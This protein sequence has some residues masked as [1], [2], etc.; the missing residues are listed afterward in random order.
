VD[1]RSFASEV[2][3]SAIKNFG[4]LLGEGGRVVECDESYFGGGKFNRGRKA[5]KG[6]WVFGAYE[7]GTKK[8]YFTKVK[9]RNS[10][11][12]SKIIKEHI[13]PGATVYTD[14]WRGYNALNKLGYNH[15]TV[16]HS[17]EFVSSKDKKV[18]TQNIE[19]LWSTIKSWEQRPGKLRQ[20]YHQY[21]ARYAFCAR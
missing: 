2:C 14:Q 4:G 13:C 19:R 6:F 8:V 12:L 3:A 10:K 17:L 7:R 15:K 1:W 18:H 21:F 5:F 11:T 20:Y 9:N 16:N